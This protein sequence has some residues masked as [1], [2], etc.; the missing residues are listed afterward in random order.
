MKLLY[1]LRNMFPYCIQNFVK[2]VYMKWN[3]PYSICKHVFLYDLMKWSVKIW[4]NV[5][6]WDIDGVVWEWCEIGDYTAL[7]GNTKIYSSNDFNV[8]IWKFCSI[9]A[10]CSFIAD[11]DHDYKRLTT[12][13]WKFKPTD[14]K[15]WATITIWHDVWIWK[16][17][18]ILKWVSVWTGAIIW[19]WS[20]VTNDVPPYGIV[21]WNPAKVI[22]YR[23]DDKTIKKLL[24]SE[25]WNRDIEKIKEN[26]NLEFLR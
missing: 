21:V 7:H 22:K 13:T 5:F 14:L 15:V 3:M 10:W 20:V 25:R 1:Y 8:K 24:Q 12:Y 4:K 9:S 26:Y 23:F 11:E 2:Y 6:I 19:S 17:A 16:N 18:I